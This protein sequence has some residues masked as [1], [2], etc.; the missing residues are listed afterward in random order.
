MAELVF[1]ACHTGVLTPENR[2]QL[3]SV[4]LQPFVSEEERSAIDR[5][6]YAIRRGWLS[7]TN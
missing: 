1:Q 7:L 5:L 4:L 6:L 2:K 3:Q